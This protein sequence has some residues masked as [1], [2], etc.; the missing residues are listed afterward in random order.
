LSELIRIMN[1][2]F[3]NKQVVRNGVVLLALC[4]DNIQT[5]ATVQKE[6]GNDLICRVIKKYLSSEDIVY[7]DLILMENM[8]RMHKE[9]KQEYLDLK[10][11]LVVENIVDT[12]N[13]DR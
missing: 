13:P 2:F 4:S 8:I 5:V 3:K 12:C 10:V 1:D 6:K 9:T 7:N 11:D